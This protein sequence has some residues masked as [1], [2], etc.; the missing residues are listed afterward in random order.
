MLLGVT[1]GV[2]I[3]E[4]VGVGAVFRVRIGTQEYDRLSAFYARIAP[5]F[6]Q[7][8]C[9][10]RYRLLLSAKALPTLRPFS[11]PVR[12]EYR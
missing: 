12:V 4:L 2:C 1:I 3:R 8:R 5:A 9:G 10:S 7:L 6:L 11:T